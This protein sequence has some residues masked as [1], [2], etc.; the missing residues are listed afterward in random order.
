MILYFISYYILVE[1][2][3]SIIKNE[4]KTKKYTPET[5]FNKKIINLLV[6]VLCKIESKRRYKNYS[7]FIPTYPINTFKIIFIIE[8]RSL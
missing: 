8:Y 6:Q 4:Q 3:K 1:E 5:N 7:N 2:F